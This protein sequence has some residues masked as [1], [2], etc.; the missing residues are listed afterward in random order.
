M[1]SFPFPH[2]YH[3]TRA[4]NVEDIRARG[5]LSS[6][7]GDVHGTM[8]YAPAGDSVYLSRH[9]FSSNLNMNLFTGS[10]GKPEEVVVLTIDASHLDPDLVFPDD[11]MLYAMDEQVIGEWEDETDEERAEIVRSFSERYGVSEAEGLEVIEACLRDGERGYPHA[12]KRIWPQL[13]RVEGEVAY[14]GDV[15]PEAIVGVKPYDRQ[16]RRP[17]HEELAVFEP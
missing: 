13:L 7:Y 8:D 6:F 15:P 11:S 2:L 16:A 14:M 10:D 5:L 1:T 9:E 4:R 17:E 12:L 3:A